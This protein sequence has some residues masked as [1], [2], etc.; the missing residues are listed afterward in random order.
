MNQV[1]DSTSI[2]DFNKFLKPADFKVLE[3]VKNSIKIAN[4][5][6]EELAD[7]LVCKELIEKESKIIKLN[8]NHIFHVECLQN[9]LQNNIISCP[10]CKKLMVY[11]DYTPLELS[12]KY[13]PM[14]ELDINIDDVV[15]CKAFGNKLIKITSIN[16]NIYSGNFLDLN[17]VGSF[18]RESLIHKK[19]QNI[20]CYECEKKSIVDYHYLGHK[21]F[22]CGSYNTT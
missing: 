1:Q 17:I 21:C 12:I 6:I 14:P 5:E 10:L 15:K 4:N 19:Q 18:N 9:A 7:C 3:Y 11:I 2:C 22:N 8:C 13:Q 20:Y 16:N